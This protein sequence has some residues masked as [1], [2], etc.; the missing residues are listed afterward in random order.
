[1]DLVVLLEESLTL[2]PGKL[3]IESHLCKVLT[4]G[5]TASG[6]KLNF[7]SLNNESIISVV[8]K[9]SLLPST[10]PTYLLMVSTETTSP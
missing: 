5:P 1:M 2:P 7:A 4:L 10:I 6:R 3:E 8:Q 9:I